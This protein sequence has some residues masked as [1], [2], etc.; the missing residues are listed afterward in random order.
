MCYMGYVNY[1]A[2]HH[3][4][5]GSLGTVHTYHG[6]IRLVYQTASTP[7]APKSDRLCFT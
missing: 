6:G 7:G 3:A 4:T 2:T 1:E 5:T